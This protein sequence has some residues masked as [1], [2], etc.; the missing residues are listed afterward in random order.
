MSS[1][2]SPPIQPNPNGRLYQVSAAPRNSTAAVQFPSLGP[3][4]LPP[5]SSILGSGSPL[6]PPSHLQPIHVPS[7]PQ[8]RLGYSDF[9]AYHRSSNAYQHPFSQPPSPQNRITGQ[10][11]APLTRILHVSP[12]TTSA[13]NS[14]LSP[15][16]PPQTFESSPYRESP[17]ELIKGHLAKDQFTAS[18]N[19]SPYTKY[20][21]N[22]ERAGVFQSSTASPDSFVPTPTHVRRP[23]ESRQR[24]P[25]MWVFEH[26]LPITM[27]DVL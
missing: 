11:A 8:M 7:S 25:D 16:Y 12:Y 17:Y 21:Q 19:T 5:P 10:G 2:P 26:G 1:R 20:Q 9:A 18:I 23:T 22:Q 6:S 4:T 27:A 3:T 24:L 15:L 13:S 14:P